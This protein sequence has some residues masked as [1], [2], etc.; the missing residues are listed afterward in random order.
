MEKDDLLIDYVP[1]HSGRV[2]PKDT[3]TVSPEQTRQEL[4]EAITGSNDVL[5]RATTTLTLFPDTITLDRAKLTVTKRNFVSSA[6]LVSIRIEDILNVTVSVGPLF[7]MVEITSRIPSTG[8]YKVGNFWRKDALKIKRITQ[9]YVIALQ[10]NIDCNSLP[11]AELAFMLDK[12][13]EDDH[14]N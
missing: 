13:G 11:T 9:G 8:P 10:R 5:V 3:R 2:E 14:E 12:L 7:G 1:R 6:E 4:R